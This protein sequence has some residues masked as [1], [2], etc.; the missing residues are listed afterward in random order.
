MPI[1]VNASIRSAFAYI[2]N[3]YG[4]TGQNLALAIRRIAKKLSSPFRIIRKPFVLRKSEKY[5]VHSRDIEYVFKARTYPGSRTRK[6]V[7]HVP[8]GYTGNK[9]LPLVMVLHGCN[10]THRD[11][12]A[13]SAFDTISD[14]AG[15]LVVYPFVRAVNG[16][17][18]MGNQNCWG[19][20][21]P[22]EIR[23]GAGEVE[24]LWQIIEEIKTHYNVDSQRIHVTG[25]S[26]GAGMTVAMLVAHAGRIA[27]GATVAGVPYYETSRAVKV[28][29]LL[30]P[31]HKPVATVVSAMN[32]ELGKNKQP[33][34]IFIVHS[35]DDETVGM[36][37]AQNLRDSWA[38][39]FGVDITSKMKVRNGSIKN[40][41][42]E[43]TRYRGKNGRT[44]IET[45]FLQG[46]GHGWY[47]GKP[48]R[49]SYPDAPDISKL[50]WLF[51][52]RHPLQTNITAGQQIEQRTVL[53]SLES[54]EGS[55]QE[56]CSGG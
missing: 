27:S 22:S 45:F 31:Q 18:G 52:R 8:P 26:S 3:A 37:A 9:A 23:S 50:I 29:Q 30:R 20:W 1:R 28:L 33:L 56:F 21:L 48:G 11:I 46:P 5:Q 7:I 39:C 49:F 34:P 44:F 2:K 16:Y 51:F 19:W 47:G 32:A 13:I 42:W 53:P 4:K 6:Y 54:D 43:H 10:Q 14:R 12:K 36:T 41:H 24:D 17:F 15:F 40:T 38:Q 35:L 25:L 55:L